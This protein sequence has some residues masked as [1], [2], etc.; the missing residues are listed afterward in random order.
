MET[1]TGA[2]LDTL[3]AFRFTHLNLVVVLR[4]L[5]CAGKTRNQENHDL[6]YEIVTASGAEGE[7]VSRG[8]KRFADCPPYEAFL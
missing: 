3:G 6:I 2:Y 5:R 7:V 1:F 4:N 8:N